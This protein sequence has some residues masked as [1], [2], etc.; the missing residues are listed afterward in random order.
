MQRWQTLDDELDGDTGFRRRSLIN[1]AADEA[2]MQTLQ[3]RQALMHGQG[4][5]HE[6]MIDRQELRERLPHV[7]DYCVGGVVSETDG[8]AIPINRYLPFGRL[9]PGPVRFLL[10]ASRYSACAGLATTGWWKPPAAATK[11]SIW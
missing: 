11:P 3:K 1:I 2:D 8:Y 10:K 9:L 5:F 7:A 4:Y 6:T